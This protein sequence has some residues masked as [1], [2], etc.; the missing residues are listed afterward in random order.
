MIT[1]NFNNA[2]K[3]LLGIVMT[4]PSVYIFNCSPTSL[5]KCYLIIYVGAKT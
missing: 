3:G 4:Y 1:P 5:R 2:S